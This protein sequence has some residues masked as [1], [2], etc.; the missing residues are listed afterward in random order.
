MHREKNFYDHGYGIGVFEIPEHYGKFLQEGDF[1]KYQPYCYM[2]RL[3]P[4]F[5]VTR[6]LVHRI[7]KSTDDV[8]EARRLWILMRFE[9]YQ[10]AKWAEYNRQQLKHY[11]N[12]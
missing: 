6:F 2:S 9:K 5:W 11:R 8:S 10:E 4:L 1:E 3:N 12:I 7:T